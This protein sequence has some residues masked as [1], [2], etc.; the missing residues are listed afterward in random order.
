[1]RES[2]L[3]LAIKIRPNRPAY[4]LS[5]GAVCNLILSACSKCMWCT[6]HKRRAFENAHWKRFGALFAAA[7]WPAAILSFSLIKAARGVM[8]LWCVCIYLSLRLP[9]VCV[10]FL[11]CWVEECHASSRYTLWSPPLMS[12]NR[13]SQINLCV[14]LIWTHGGGSS[15]II[16]F[17][18]DPL[19][20]AAKFTGWTFKGARPAK[21]P[22]ERRHTH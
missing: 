13:D 11:F 17:L 10:R 21:L 2:V 16:N 6:L 9:G 19:L 5:L 14:T 22:L 1:M 15:A 3:H 20:T 7:A 12:G 8:Q 18:L 4:I